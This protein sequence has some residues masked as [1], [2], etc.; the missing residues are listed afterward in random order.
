MQGQAGGGRGE[1]GQTG[2]MLGGRG[3]LCFVLARAQPAEP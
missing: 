2:R 3:M 1:G